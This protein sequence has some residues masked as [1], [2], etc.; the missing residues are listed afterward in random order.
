MITPGS[1]VRRWRR[2]ALPAAGTGFTALAYVVLVV[3]AG[4][5]AG[6]GGGHTWPAGRWPSLGAMVVVALAVQ[7]LRRRLARLAGRPARPPAGVRDP[8][9][10]ARAAERERLEQAIRLEV[11]PYL[12]T[13]SIRLRRAAHQVPDARADRLLSTVLTD[14]GAA[15]ERLRAIC[16]G[17]PPSRERPRS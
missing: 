10:A 13:A 5:V 7:P 9:D 2:G 6:S 16:R 3:S 14:T 8:V 17:R 11:V 12:E 1:F 4:V 15:L